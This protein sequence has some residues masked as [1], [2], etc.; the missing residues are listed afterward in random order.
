MSEIMLL[1]IFGP[2]TAGGVLLFLPN[3]LR[4][5]IRLVGVVTAVMV[6]AGAVY[7]A[8]QAPSQYVVSLVQ[9]GSLDLS[10]ILSVTVLNRVILVF[11]A[12]F[13][14][15]IALYALPAT[16]N[17]EHQS[18]LYGS[19]LVAVGAA[20][21]ILLSGHL[22]FLLVF[23]EIATAALYLL[24]T[25]GGQTS[26]AAATKTFA[27]IGA[28]D[29]ALLLGIAILWKLT[30]TF[31]IARMHVATDSAASI[32]A[33]VLLMLAAVTKA[34]AMPLHTWLPSSGQVAHAAVMA[35]LPAAIDKL[36]GIYLLVLLVRDLFVVQS[37]ALS[38][39]LAAVGAATILLAVMVA[40]VQHN[41]KKLLSYHAIS[42]V[43]Y[44]VLGIATLTPVGIAGGVFHMLN[45]AIYKCC[46]F[47][48]AGSVE[49]S[50][51]TDELDK[52]GGLGNRMPWTFTACLIGALSISGIPPL[53]GFVSKWM[54][55]QGIIQM[56]LTGSGPASWLW[57][58]WLVAAMFGSI[59]TL[60]SFVK[61]LHSVFLSRLP[62]AG[63]EVREAPPLMLIPMGVLAVLCVVLGVFYALPLDGWLRP[64]LNLGWADIFGLWDSSLAAALL[65]VG[66]LL[67]GGIVWLATRSSRTRSVPTWTCGEVQANDEM[68]V[69]GTHFYK[70]ISE[71]TPFRQIYRLQEGGWFDLYNYGGRVG[72]AF[73]DLLKWLHNGLLPGYVTWILLGLLV[74]IFFLYR[75]A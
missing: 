44:M 53:N 62:S 38:T 68:I 18:T 48:C 12:G 19:L 46:L 70:T 22:L 17:V 16:R 51:G 63:R 73:S 6:L 30:G 49:H 3:T 54:V 8:M 60:A 11:A 50:A 2:L 57:P 32:T 37:Q 5:L 29:G 41:V 69:P 14:L 15:L 47:L 74:L 61:I 33:F 59:L 4:S 39:I 36:L 64:A 31:E 65:I 26:K 42:Q 75:I 66:A 56:G 71:Q 20:A 28:S 23:W 67:A 35:V 40:M 21:G 52:L 72:L 43:G 25:T 34:G 58:I 13:G 45:H 9:T 27:M 24:I 10:L 1:L 55:Y 7:C